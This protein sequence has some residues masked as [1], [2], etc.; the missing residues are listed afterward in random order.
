MKGDTMPEEKFYYTDATDCSHGPIPV[1]KSW[2]IKRF[3]RLGP[4][5]LWGDKFWTKIE[6]EDG[7]LHDVVYG[8]RGGVIDIAPMF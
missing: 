8:P 5:R 3:R 7:T 2:L 6:D 1:T 4:P